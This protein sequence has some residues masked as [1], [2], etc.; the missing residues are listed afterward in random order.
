MWRCLPL[1]GVAGEEKLGMTCALAHVRAAQHTGTRSPPPL[2][3]RDGSSEHDT[4]RTYDTTQQIVLN[5]LTVPHWQ[6]EL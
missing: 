1:D 3:F 5:M 6:V 4:R 2:T